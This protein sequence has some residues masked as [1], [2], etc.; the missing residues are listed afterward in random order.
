MCDGV[1]ALLTLDWIGFLA[2]HIILMSRKM[3]LVISNDI[4]TSLTYM[5][6]VKAEFTEGSDKKS[7]D[8]S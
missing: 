1:N 4:I 2:Q 7:R 8:C 6:P 3:L 5:A